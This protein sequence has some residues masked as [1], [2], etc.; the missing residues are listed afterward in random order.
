MQR[1]ELRVPPLRY[2]AIGLTALVVI[3]H[4]AAQ[5]SSS[6]YAARS[7][8]IHDAVRDKLG[9]GSDGMPVGWHSGSVGA[10]QRAKDLSAQEEWYASRGEG[11]TT[12]ASA[13]FTILSRNSDVWEVVSAMQSL[14]DRCEKCRPYPWVFLN[15]EP[16]NDEFKRATSSVAYG[17]CHYGLVPKEHWEEP[18]WIDEKRASEERKKMEEAQRSIYGGSKTYRRMCRYESGFFFR[19]PLVMPYKYYFRIDPSVKFYCDIPYDPFL[20]MERNGWK[21]GWTISLPEYDKTIP[22][23]WD[24]TKDFIKQNPEYLA[25]PNSMAWISD[26]KGETYNRCHFW[27]NFEIGSLEFLRS[28]AYMRY[29]EHLDRAGGFSYER[30]GDAPVHSIAAALFLKTEEVHF[31]EDIGYFHNPFQNCPIDPA[32]HA[33]RK[34]SCNP[35]HENNFGN[36]HW[37]SCDDKWRKLVGTM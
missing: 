17:A 29:F 10:A 33:E 18:A 12:L 23:L 37:Y 31:F 25:K 1:T 7:K 28:D 15:D 20:E 19:H 26:D 6:S 9:L 4:Y 3:L 35:K 14:L 30:W 24:T 36:H 34:C 2:I 27:S 8:E 21:Y 5:S 13:A 11:N 22:T 32:L 16:F